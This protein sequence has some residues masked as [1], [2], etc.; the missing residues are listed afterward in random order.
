MRSEVI[1]CAMSIQPA[2][3]RSRMWLLARTVRIYTSTPSNHFIPA[4]NFWCGTAT[5][6]P[7]AAIT[8]HWHNWLLITQVC[9]GPIWGHFKKR[10]WI[11]SVLSC[12]SIQHAR[13]LNQSVNQLTR[14]FVWLFKNCS[15]TPTV[16]LWIEKHKGGDRSP[17]NREAL[18]PALAAIF[19]KDDTN[20]ETL[21]SISVSLFSLPTESRLVS[22]WHTKQSA[23]IHKH[24]GCTCQQR[25]RIHAPKHSFTRTRAHTRGRLRCWQ[26]SGTTPLFIWLLR[27]KSVRKHSSVTTWT[28]WQDDPLTD[29]YLTECWLFVC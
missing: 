8:L 20:F 23:F 18:S 9:L 5:S 1:G 10:Y 17:G 14:S 21:D 16:L 28:S 25:N 7:S 22:L 2:L 24:K 26:H 15:V 12:I 3:W 29:W 19:G 4:K 11:L 27:K 6:L 13:S